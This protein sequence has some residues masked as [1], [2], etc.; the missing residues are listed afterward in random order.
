MKVERWRGTGIEMLGAPKAGSDEFL[1]LSPGTH[2]AS[3]TP[4][5]GILC[6]QA[7]YVA[8]Q[9]CIGAG[10]EA[11]AARHKTVRKQILEPLTRQAYDA[12]QAVLV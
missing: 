9:R 3:P 6:E 10:P 12:H 4:S 7:V 8:L 1:A 11:G 2:T 5:Y